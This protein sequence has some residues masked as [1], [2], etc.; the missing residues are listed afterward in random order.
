M[1]LRYTRRS[2]VLSLLHSNDIYDLATALKVASQTLQILSTKLS[3]SPF[4]YGS[5][6][7]GVTSLDV[8]SAAYV[9]L[10]CYG[11][12]TNHDDFPLFYLMIVQC[13]PSLLAHADRV[14]RLSGI[15]NYRTTVDYA[16]LTPSRVCD[17]LQF[18][19]ETTVNA[20]RLP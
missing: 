19:H 9:A 10:L 20:P 5:T 13:Y 17:V 11:N 15:P 7:D 18:I 4:Y 14:L 1:L 2:K 3:T 12:F 8:T 16:S 6:S